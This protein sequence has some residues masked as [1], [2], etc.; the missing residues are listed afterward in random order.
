MTNKELII[1][2]AIG[3]NGF[4]TDD[5]TAG[6]INPEYWNRQLLRYLEPN[7][8]IANK[9]AV[10]DDILGQ[11][12]ASF[13]VTIDATPTAAAAVD[14]SDDIP[15]TAFETTSQ[16]VFTPTEYAKA[17]QL[18]DKQARRGFFDAMANMTMKLGFALAL[19]RDDAAEALLRTG[20]GNSIVANGVDS[21]DLAS[22]DTLS[23]DDI[24]D[25]VKELR[26][27]LF[28]A[29]YLFVSPEGFAQLAKDQNFKFVNHAGTDE[30]LRDGR[31]GTIYGLTVYETTQI[32][33]DDNASKAIVLGT[34][35]I[36]FPVF[37]I[38]RK[39]LPQL[40]TQAWALGRYTDVAAV[41]EWDMKILRADGICTIE[42]YA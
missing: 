21:S 30:T 4:T 12:G 8:V 39:L 3:A 29:R 32:G 2:N 36:G 22:S 33:V 6:H 34:D 7:L 18:S 31:I 27:D 42:H 25:A 24:V 35:Q 11:D 37:G 17:Y 1:A 28:V 14:E 5:T 13:K 40:R 26:K 41:E 38:G 23:Y 10:Y 15:V 20:A 16:V 9:A 19:G